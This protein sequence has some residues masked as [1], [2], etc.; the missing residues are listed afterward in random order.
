[1]QI[2]PKKKSEKLYQVSC[3]I[4]WIYKLTC[5]ISCLFCIYNVLLFFKLW[6]DWFYLT[7]IYIIERYIVPDAGAQGIVT[8]GPWIIVI[9]VNYLLK[10]SIFNMCMIFCLIIAEF[11]NS[12]TISESFIMFSKLICIIIKNNNV[13]ENRRDNRDTH[14]ALN[15]R[16]RQNNA[17]K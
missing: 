10:L 3:N 15:T 1:M 12:K 13:R 6:Y 4:F 2:F 14:A 17:R 11:C 7:V 9:D 5:N 16:Y 8:I